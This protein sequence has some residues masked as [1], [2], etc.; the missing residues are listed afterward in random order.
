[1]CTGRFFGVTCAVREQCY[2]HT[3]P[4]SRMQSWIIGEPEKGADCK[5]FWKV[6]ENED[7]SGVFGGADAG[8]APER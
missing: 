7:R 3:A 6:E 5:D 2:R 8:A 1:M 4:M